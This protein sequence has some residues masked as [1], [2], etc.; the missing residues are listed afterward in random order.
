MKP[1]SLPVPEIA[2]RVP[3]I[4]DVDRTKM[5]SKRD[6]ATRAAPARRWIDIAADGSPSIKAKSTAP[7][8]PSEI[9]GLQQIAGGDTEQRRTIPSEE[10]IAAYRKI[11]D[12]SQ[13]APRALAS[14]SILGNDAA[15]LGNNAA[16]DPDS[17]PP[18]ISLNIVV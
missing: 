3:P 18:T 17:A 12:A 8:S 4:T 11:H 14:A 5:L 15:I 13:P 6:E 9:I 1:L 10:G 2:H 7:A 16:I